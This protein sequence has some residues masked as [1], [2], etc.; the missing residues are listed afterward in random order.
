MS[1]KT[2][3]T[4][5][6]N[7]HYISDNQGCTK[8]SDRFDIVNCGDPFISFVILYDIYVNTTSDYGCFNTQFNR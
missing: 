7:T 1:I 2:D 4:R 8:K 3:D 5:R 6:N